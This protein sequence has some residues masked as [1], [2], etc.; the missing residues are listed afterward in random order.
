[1]L[2]VFPLFSAK[3]LIFHALSCWKPFSPYII[4]LHSLL[5]FIM[6]FPDMQLHL[7]LSSFRVILPCLSV[8]LRNFRNLPFFSVFILPSSLLTFTYRVTPSIHPSVCFP[9]HP[10]VHLFY[11][12][13]L[14][15]SF[16]LFLS[17]CDSCLHLF[18][19]LCDFSLHL[20]PPRAH[21]HL[22]LSN[23]R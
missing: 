8:T 20:T 11:F 22:T 7:I 15:L 9:I 21:L 14:I 12:L 1:M 23:K 19:S 17:S 10:S 4:S 2:F 3:A 5:H 13:A 18:V 6:D 16:L